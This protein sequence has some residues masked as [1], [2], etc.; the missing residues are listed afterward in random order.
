MRTLIA[1]CVAVLALIGLALPAAADDHIRIHLLHGIPD[2][3]VDVEA[4]GENAIEDFAFGDTQDLSALAGAT[5]ADL[6]VK[7]AGTETVAIDA[8]DVTLPSEGNFTIVAHL[9][10]EGTPTIS[11]FE[12]DESTIAAGSGRL[13]VRHTAAAPAVDV[14]A[15]GAV[16]FGD[17]P[18][19]EEAAAD[20]PVATYTAEVVP[21]GEDGPVVIGPAPLGVTDG[22]Q[23]IVYAVGSLAD[24]TLTVLTE[25]IDGLGSAP[26]R[27]ETGN[28][29]VDDGAPIT[30][31]LL[32]VAIAAAAAAAGS[33]TLVRRRAT[34][35][36]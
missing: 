14:L 12:N 11:V 9:D 8:G 13:A 18:N 15:D 27:V 7:V 3:T 33:A 16:A 2:V 25:S 19:G 32:L 29:P 22:T 21:A 4:G 34:V 10:A 31:S 30:N 28:S 20:L 23:L 36:A 6:K 5:L 1:A 17:L 26:A 24:E 35:E